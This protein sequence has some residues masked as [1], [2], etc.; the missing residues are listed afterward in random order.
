MAMTAGSSAGKSYSEIN[1]TPL[2]DAMLGLLIIFIITLPS[3][4]QASKIDKPV[5]HPAES[6]PPPELID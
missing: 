3:Q 6:T 5:P 2:I 1:M 4:T